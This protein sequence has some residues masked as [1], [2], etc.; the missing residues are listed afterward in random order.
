MTT[1]RRS[2]VVTTRFWQRQGPAAERITELWWLFLAMG[3]AVYI[4][5]IVLLLV[6]MFRRG[7]QAVQEHRDDDLTDV[8]PEL[9][10]RWIVGF[11]VVL[12]LVLLIVALVAS[13]STMRALPRTAPP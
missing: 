12:P 4:L 9:A 8:P 6:P 1:A 3:A 11:G 2:G 7:R 5:V 10:N 13:V